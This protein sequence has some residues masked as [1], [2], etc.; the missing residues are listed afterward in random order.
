LFIINTLF[1]SRYPVSRASSRCPCAVHTRCHASFVHVVSCASS[2]VICV[3]RASGARASPRVIR[4][5]S[6]VYPRVVHASFARVVHV[7]R[8][9]CFHAARLVHVSRVSGLGYAVTI[10]SSVQGPPGVETP[11]VTLSSECSGS[12]SWSKSTFPFQSTF[13]TNLKNTQAHG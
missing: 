2:R 11:T 5:L 13:E 3:C 10:H 9:H 7:C 12:L 1:V 8:A 4:T 6:H